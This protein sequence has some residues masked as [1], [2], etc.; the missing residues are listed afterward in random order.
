[1]RRTC[2]STS[3]SVD[4]AAHQGHTLERPLI[5]WGEPAFRST[6]VS[7][8]Q[9]ERV[10]NKR[11]PTAHG[12]EACDPRGWVDHGRCTIDSC[13]TKP[14]QATKDEGGV[15]EANWT[16]QRWIWHKEAFFFFE[17]PWTWW[18]GLDNARSG[19]KKPSFNGHVLG[20]LDEID[21]D[22]FF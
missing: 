16:W 4:S 11:E 13:W 21:L 5:K 20:G 10:T 6:R 9:Q 19:I 14:T 12:A 3:A 22:Q 8:Q 17:Q 2:L 15:R 1:M 18:I 7:T